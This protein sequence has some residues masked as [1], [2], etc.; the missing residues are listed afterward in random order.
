M[1][2]AMQE[3]F[4]ALQFEEF[5]TFKKNNSEYVPMFMEFD[6]V[7]M[8]VRLHDKFTV[9][10]TVVNDKASSS[11]KPVVVELLSDIMNYSVLASIVPD[12]ADFNKR[13]TAKQEEFFKSL[14]TVAEQQLTPDVLMS[15]VFDAYRTFMKVFTI[16]NNGIMYVGSE[17]DKTILQL[18]LKNMHVYAGLLVLEIRKSVST[19]SDS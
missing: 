5:E 13:F 12:T 14:D 10:R 8:V 11:V 2:T 6:L 15:Q 16:A 3:N 19:Q 18:T 4:A 17:L 1:L 7:G 9:L